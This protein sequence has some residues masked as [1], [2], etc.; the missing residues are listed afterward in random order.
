MTDNTTIAVLPADRDDRRLRLV[1]LS[2][3]GAE[4][5]RLRLSDETFSSDVGWFTQ[6][7][8]DLSPSQIR[9]LRSALGA[10]AQSSRPTLRQPTRT[11]SVP[12]SDQRSEATLLSLHRAG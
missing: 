7:T 4:G 1:M 6:G 11:E 9:D 5:A 10:P 3:G 12:S 8:I 2:G